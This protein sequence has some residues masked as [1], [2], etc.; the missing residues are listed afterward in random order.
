MATDP[1]LPQRF[2]R[3]PWSFCATPENAP[4]PHDAMSPLSVLPSNAPAFSPPTLFCLLYHIPALCSAGFRADRLRP[5]LKL[6]PWGSSPQRHD[7]CACDAGLQ[8]RRCRWEA[9]CGA[10]RIGGAVPLRLL[11][12]GRRRNPLPKRQLHRGSG[13]CDRAAHHSRRVLAV[14]LQRDE[15]GRGIHAPLCC[16]RFLLTLRTVTLPPLALT[17]PPPLSHMFVVWSRR[18]PLWLHASLAPS[19]ISRAP[20]HLSRAFQGWR[21]PLKAA[22]SKRCRFYRITGAPA[23]H[24]PPPS[25]ARSAVHAL[26]G[27]SI[28]HAMRAAL[29][30]RSA[31]RGLTARSARRHGR[32]WTRRPVHVTNVLARG[33]SLGSAWRPPPL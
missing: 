5:P 32:T 15:H 31:S 27:N 11:V 13:R 7:A 12:L 9:L 19:S 33:L 3:W 20:T 8:G 18:A 24:P 26:E 21:A 23:P 29:N 30:A 22:R 2:A 6:L 14:P 28:A 10:L 25:A 17:C 1:L 4:L 16:G